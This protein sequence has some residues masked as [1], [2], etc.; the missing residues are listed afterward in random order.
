MSL[1]DPKFLARLE[2]LELRVGRLVA[3][4]RPGDVASLRRGAGSSFRGHRGYVPGDDIRSIDWN[5]F[6]RLDELVVK[7]FDAE[8]TPR[9]TILIDASPSMATEGGVKAAMAR[10]LAAALGWIALAR[11]GSVRVIPFPGTARDAAFSGRS[12]AAAFL[13]HLETLPESGGDGLMDVLSAAYGGRR[14]P[15]ITLLLSDFWAAD[16]FESALGF[17]RRRGERVEAL[18]LWIAAE[19]SPSLDGPV[20]LTDA[21]S[22]RT[23]RVVMT[24][25]LLARHR[26]AVE[27]HFD[28][29]ARTARAFGANHHRLDAEATVESLVLDTLRAR[30]V[31]G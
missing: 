13:R 8:V 3:G 10:K 14:H 5:A 24:P 9:V 27:D 12:G 19:A 31:V 20:V 30:A 21:E 25:A 6:V 7:E 28:D 11:H 29:V 22:G 16:R 18:H 17:L 23:L 1:L 4:D 26:K 15:G 2:R